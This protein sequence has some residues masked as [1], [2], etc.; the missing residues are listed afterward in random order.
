MLEDPKGY[1]HS[2]LHSDKFR[3]VPMVIA[4]SRL[5]QILKAWQK[6]WLS[7]KPVLL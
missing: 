4:V 5:Q 6:W 1:S 2:M 3:T 7:A